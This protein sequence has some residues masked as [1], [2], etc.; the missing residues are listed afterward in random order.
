MN[1]NMQNTD[2]NRAV[3]RVVSGSRP[4]EFRASSVYNDGARKF[5][6]SVDVGASSESAA[7]S[8]S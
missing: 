8:A 2:A 7:E 5:V 3:W 6:L 4:S 1:Q